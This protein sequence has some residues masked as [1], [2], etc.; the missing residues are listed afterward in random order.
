MV[1]KVSE[2]WPFFVEKRGG[3]L[4]RYLEVTGTGTATQRA[5]QVEIRLSLIAKQNDY[6]QT[7][8]QSAN[9]LSELQQ[10]L[11]ELGFD[12]DIIQTKNYMLNTHYQPDPDS[13]VYRTVFD[14][15]RLQH[16][17]VMNFEHDN[18]RLNQLLAKLA[19]LKD[20]PEFYLSF[21]VKDPAAAEE[22]A[23]ERAVSDAKKKAQDLARLSD[24]SLGAIQYVVPG[25][26]GGAIHRMAEMKSGYDMDFPVGESAI[27]KYVTIRFAID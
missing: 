9:Q 21:R 18:E 27:T 23:M 1:I 2:S 19:S 10:L 7:L 13:P 4:K 20:Q 15:Y 25:N 8:A 12:K 22:R 5:D 3:P 24:V 17:L 26:N 14:G 6:A 11:K 16:D